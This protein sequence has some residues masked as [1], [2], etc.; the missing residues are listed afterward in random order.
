MSPH[1]SPYR[2][3][4]WADDRTRGPLCTTANFAV[5]WQ[6]W[7]Q[8]GR[9]C[10]IPILRRSVTQRARQPFYNRIVGCT[11]HPGSAVDANTFLTSDWD[12]PNCRA[13]CDGLI[14]AL[15]AARTALT[16]PRV[17]EDF[18]T[19]ACPLSL[20]GDCFW[21]DASFA[22]GHTLVGSNWPRRFASWT[23]VVMSRSSSVSVRYLTALGRS[24]GSTCRFAAA[25]AAASAAETRLVGGEPSWTKLVEKRSG[26]ADPARSRSM[27]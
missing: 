5:D 3:L 2:A 24:L 12:M 10:R 17:N 26:V 14:P 15:V 20:D 9:D 18:T 27:R 19:S 22:V 8:P 21:T 23:D 4:P 16:C 25:S 11:A 1:R 6:L 13:I 7:V